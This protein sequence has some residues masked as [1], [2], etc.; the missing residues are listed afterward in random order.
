MP[1]RNPIVAG[2]E[3][4][5][6]SIRSPDF[7]TT[8]SGWTI[9]RD[10]SAEF[11][12]VL[13]R[14]SLDVNGNVIFRGDNVLIVEDPDNPPL[15]L[16]AI[17]ADEFMY[18]DAV[19]H[20]G[21]NLYGNE[22]GTGEILSQLNISRESFNGEIFFNIESPLFPYEDSPYIR[23]RPDPELNGG[24]PHIEIRSGSY[25]SS[26][27]RPNASIF[28]TAR[29]GDN[30]VRSEIE[31]DASITTVENELYINGPIGQPTNEFNGSTVVAAGGAAVVSNA[32]S[33]STLS[34]AGTIRGYVTANSA[35]A[36]LINAS[37]SNLTATGANINV[38]RNGAVTNTTTYYRIRREIT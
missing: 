28:L 21:I 16:L 35:S 15:P 19:I 4:A 7:V 30:S 18:G 20:E 6:N 32:V 10:G 1:W 11:N 13:I 33:W 25:S 14:G 2:E 37:I 22:D 29:S 8:V 17:A 5:L 38:L 12:D 9:N 23:F 3:L 26:A 31:L 27:T 24:H 34:G 36:N